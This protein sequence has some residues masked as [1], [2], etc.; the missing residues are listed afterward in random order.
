LINAIPTLLQAGNYNVKD[1][2]NKAKDNRNAAQ[3]LI[4][5]GW[6]AAEHGLTAAKAS[7]TGA[8]TGLEQDRRNQDDTDNDIYNH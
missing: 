2:K 1:S 5:I 4:H 6:F 7:K 8:L 3:S